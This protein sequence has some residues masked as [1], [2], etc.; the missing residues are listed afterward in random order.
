MVGK[1]D[2]LAAAFGTAFALELALENLAAKDVQRIQ[3][4]QKAAVEQI[5]ELP[6]AGRRCRRCRCHGLVLFL[7]GSGNSL[8]NLIQNAVGSNTL[9]LTFEV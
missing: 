5:S 6:A 2:A 9:S 1:F 8:K 3:L 7:D 4:S